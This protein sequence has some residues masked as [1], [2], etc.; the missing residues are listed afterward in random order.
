[1]KL[2]KIVCLSLSAIFVILCSCVKPDSSSDTSLPNG[3]QNNGNSVKELNLMYCVGDSI[4]PYKAETLI[5]KQL[6]TLLYDPLVRV[7]TTFQPEYVL[8][9]SIELDGKKC[10]ITLKNVLFSDGTEVTAADVIYSYKLAKS[11]STVYASQLA[12]IVSFKADGN[13]SV[14]VTLSKADPY[15][16]NLLDFPV[17]KA[18]SD[19]LTD[20]NKIELPPIGCGRYV[21]DLE[22]F[23]L[24]AN[25]S[26]IL[27]CPNIAT[28]NLI[29][30]PDSEVVKYNLESGNTG[31]Y[32]SDL[33]DGIIPP[34]TGNMNTVSINRLVYLGLN[35]NKKAFK[36][37]SFR[38]AVSSAIDR[39]LICSNVYYSYATPAA[40]IF[41]P[42][43]E[44]AK[45]VQNIPQN[46]NTQI[47]VAYLEDIGYN[48]KD[49]DGFYVNS[50]GKRLSLTLVYYKGNTRRAECAKLI[51][52]QLKSAGI[53]IIEKA[54]G[55]NDYASA[56]KDGRFD[57]YLAEVRLL[58]NMD[59]SS[60]LMPGGSLAYGIPY[61]T[62][63]DVN[64]NDENQADSDV[65]SKYSTSL[66]LE[67]FYSGKLSLIDVVN[68][69]NAEMPLIPICYTLGVTISNTSF[70]VDN[71]SSVNDAYYGISNIK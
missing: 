53:E 20:Q 32:H 68:A 2:S 24:Y 56:L 65:E 23:K 57:L 12:E 37:E 4:N 63:N 19:K 52:K 69:F 39:A 25:A 30:S 45:G 43:W 41:N 58:N 59:V 21:P 8:A 71:I 44:D 27:G 48:S 60:L 14:N 35:L 62:D 9:D 66:A 64:K 33:S 26:H 61:N 5:N 46:S 28:I 22:N 70:T 7:N 40:G 6:S 54:Y 17:I 47:M 36:N 67:G 49:N 3:V 15:F 38:Y 51:A 29:N 42:V 13:N 55:W 16:A 1:M 31:I 18:N 50:K 10:H 34:M 11:S